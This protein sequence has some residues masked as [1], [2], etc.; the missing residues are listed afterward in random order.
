MKRKKLNND[1]TKR[2]PNEGQSETNRYFRFDLI[3]NDIL[4]LYRE[5]F[6]AWDTSESKIFSY[7]K[8]PF[9][10]LGS[11]FNRKKQAPM[12]LQFIPIKEN[13]AHKSIHQKQME[14]HG[15]RPI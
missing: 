3:R 11:L 7:R 1:A 10:F 12:S 15:N 9:T 6:N 13:A 14:Q 5:V 8:S 4:G 2:Q